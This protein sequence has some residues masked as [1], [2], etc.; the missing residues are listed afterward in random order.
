MNPKYCTSTFL[1]ATIIT[2]LLWAGLFLAAIFV[3]DIDVKV[4]ALTLV[5]CLTGNVLGMPF[6]MLASPY[7]SEPG[8]FERIGQLIAGFLSGYLLSK[9]DAL[10]NLIDLNSELA[11]GRI[12]LFVSFLVLG[13]V[14]TFIFRS[15]SDISREKGAYSSPPDTEQ[16][17]GT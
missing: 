5:I 3:G 6:G 17:S 11:I 16:N 10:I 1:P 2:S 13:A 4:I 7:K 15:Y 12:F 14:Q 8:H 9:S